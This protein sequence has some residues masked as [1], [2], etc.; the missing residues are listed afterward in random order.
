M[1]VP[2]LTWNGGEAG[3]QPLGAMID[4]LRL[5]LPDG[6]MV[7]PLATAP[8]A[9][10]PALPGIM[11]RLRGEWPCVPFGSEDLVP[12]PARWPQPSGAAVAPHGHGSNHD[13]V[14][15]QD[16]SGLHAVIDYPDTA[17]IHRLERLLQPDGAGVV[18][19]LRVTPRRDCCLPIALHPVLRL[20][21]TA[22]AARLDVGQHKAVW[23]HP[24]MPPADPCPLAPDHVS[25]ALTQ[26][27]RADGGAI[28]LTRLPLEEAAECRVLI[29]DA[30]GHASLSHLQ[31]DWKV[32]LDWDRADFPGLM[33]WVSNRG[34]AHA[35][36]NSRHLALGVEP[37]RAAFDLGQ[38]VSAAVNPLA[39]VMPTVQTFHAGQ[40]WESRYRI[41]V[42]PLTD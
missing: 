3:L 13:W 28:D 36:W 8:W 32:T 29:P 38:T 40:V 9:D 26:M 4:G 16:G 21:D 22:G 42:A 39:D 17:P 35:P 24:Q 6:R 30:E 19:T 15:T 27:R 14:V 2:R 41:G 31:E 25:P 12:L 33:L 23:S 1:S 5:R 7:T 20:P 34:R 18:M 11:R 37:C 10:D